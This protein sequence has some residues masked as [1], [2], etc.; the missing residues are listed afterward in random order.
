M[1]VEIWITRRLHCLGLFI[2]VP[3]TAYKLR[4]NRRSFGTRHLVDDI[5]S[6][7]YTLD[8]HAAHCNIIR[9]KNRR[10]HAKKCQ[11]TTFFG[12][13][14]FFLFFP[15]TFQPDLVEKKRRSHRKSNIFLRRRSSR[16]S[17]GRGSYASTTTDG[18]IDRSRLYGLLSPLLP[19]TPV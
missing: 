4:N 1:W 2:Y 6:H 14:R 15:L 10:K 5:T 19:T 11:L 9:K 13:C 8:R 3:T 18:S 16:Q 17:T 7:R 12:F